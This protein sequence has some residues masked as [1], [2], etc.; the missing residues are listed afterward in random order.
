MVLSS[1]LAKFQSITSLILVL[2]T[3]LEAELTAMR[4]KSHRRYRELN[5]EPVMARVKKSRFWLYIGTCIAAGVVVT[6]A[7]P[8]ITSLKKQAIVAKAS[9]S[10][11]N[12]VWSDGFD[13]NTDWDARW[14]KT[15]VTRT[16]ISCARQLYTLY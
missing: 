10:A 15:G 12:T 2:H 7:P 13:I 6:V 5:P 14:P 16:V 4:S 1:L 9:V 3:S 8:V 11:G